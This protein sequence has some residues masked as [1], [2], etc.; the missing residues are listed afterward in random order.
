MRSTKII[1]DCTTFWLPKQGNATNEYEDAFSPNKGISTAAEVFRCAVA[2]GATEASFSQSWAKILANGYVEGFDLPK[3]QEAW[4]TETV[5]QDL[6]WY[7]EEKAQM[8]AFAALVGLTIGAD[9]QWESKAI[10]DSCL[11]QARNGKIIHTFPLSKAE[12]FND[13]P[14]LLSSNEANNEK[15]ETFW[16]NA[17]GIW[18]NKDMFLLMT[19][20]LSQWLF[21]QHEQGTDALATLLALND[22]NDFSKMIQEARNQS[23]TSKHMKNDDVTLMKLIVKSTSK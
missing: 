22:Q 6:A 21:R 15:I 5:K 16:L 11:V 12:Q 3:L 19:D 13:S 20:A 14:F 2:D 7:A 1:V 10:G 18:K 17:S 23:D 9:K 8:G 4:R